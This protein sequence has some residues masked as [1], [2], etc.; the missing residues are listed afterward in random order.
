M[1]KFK[2]QSHTIY[3]C[4]YHIVYCVSTIGL[5]EEKIRKHVKHQERKEK[6]EES[7]QKEFRLF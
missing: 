3:Q 4:M 1:S 5:D 7:Q 2:K 6:E